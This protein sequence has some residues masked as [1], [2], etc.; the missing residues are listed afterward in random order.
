[1]THV[2]MTLRIFERRTIENDIG[3]RRGVFS[4]GGR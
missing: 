2:N 3:E 1:M 4:E